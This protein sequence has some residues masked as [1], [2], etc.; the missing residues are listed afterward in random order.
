MIEEQELD[1][2]EKNQLFKISMSSISLSL[3]LIYPRPQQLKAFLN[4]SHSRPQVP[5]PRPESELNASHLT[6][7]IVIIDLPVCHLNSD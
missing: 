5:D 4:T 6:Y 2:E 3:Y 7:C 1:I